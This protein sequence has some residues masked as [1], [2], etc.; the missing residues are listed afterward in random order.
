MSSL[1]IQT[2]ANMTTSKPFK[3]V[4]SCCRLMHCFFLQAFKTILIQ[5]YGSKASKPNRSIDVCQQLACMIQH[6]HPFLLKNDQGCEAKLERKSSL[7]C[8]FPRIFSPTIRASLK[9]KLLARYW[10]M[11]SWPSKRAGMSSGSAIR[12]FLK[13]L[14]ADHSP[15]SSVF[16]TF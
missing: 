15:A 9:Q 11:L 10:L 6:I 8:R 2:D 12:K 3:L 5:M 14:T 1:Q 13:L 7:F 4:I 16:L